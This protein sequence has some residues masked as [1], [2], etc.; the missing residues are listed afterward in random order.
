MRSPSLLKRA[1]EVIRGDQAQRKAG[2][3]DIWVVLALCM[4]RAGPEGPGYVDI[5][6]IILCSQSC[7]SR[8]APEPGNRN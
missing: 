4:S 3:W 1:G 6:Q 8:H 5:P 7:C 2:I